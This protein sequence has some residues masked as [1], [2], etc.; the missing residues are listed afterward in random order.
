MDTLHVLLPRKEVILRSTSRLGQWIGPRAQR[1][2]GRFKQAVPTTPSGDVL[3]YRREKSP[4]FPSD[5]LRF[6]GR[7]VSTETCSKWVH[8]DYPSQ[9]VLSSSAVSTQLTLMNSN[10][11]T[12]R[13]LS[14]RCADQP[15]TPSRARLI[16]TSSD[17]SS[18]RFQ[19]DRK[20]HEFAY[21]KR[22]QKQSSQTKSKLLFSISLVFLHFHFI[23]SG[24]RHVLD[25]LLDKGT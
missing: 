16:K 21:H 20:L 22:T 11:Q 23:V 8:V 3:E 15:A 13:S 1:E 10:S 9:L 18:S 6:S 25:A 17:S 12:L 7:C 14:R 4:S 19:V 2:A 5:L 24:T